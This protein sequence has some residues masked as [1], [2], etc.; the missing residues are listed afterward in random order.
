MVPGDPC[1]AIHGSSSMTSSSMAIHGH[2]YCIGD[3]SEPPNGLDRPWGIHPTPYSRSPPPIS[4]MP[5]VPVASYGFHHRDPVVPREP[6]GILRLPVRVLWISD[7]SLRSPRIPW[8]PKVLKHSYS[9]Q[10]DPWIPWGIPLCSM[11]CIAMYGHTWVP[12]VP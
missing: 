8:I 4:W 12:M 1:M 10:W 5:T 11:H 3:P 6:S 9:V 7:G 2:A